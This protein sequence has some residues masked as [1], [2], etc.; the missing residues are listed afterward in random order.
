M[1][2]R[3]SGL[4]QILCRLAKKNKVL[5]AVPLKLIN[6]SENKPMMLGRIMQN[7][8]LCRRYKVSQ[9]IASFAEKPYEMKSPNDLMSLAITLG[10]DIAPAKKSLNSVY[11]KISENLKKRSPDY[12]G[13]GIELKG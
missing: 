7:I 10:M 2:F 3:A 5:I 1:H 6:N 11:E 4:N 9:L 12:L 13:E 8:I